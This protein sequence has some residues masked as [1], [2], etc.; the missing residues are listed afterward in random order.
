MEDLDLLY[1]HPYKPGKFDLLFSRN[2]GRNP[3]PLLRDQHPLR[4]EHGADS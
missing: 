4:W 3:W 1:E 2:Q